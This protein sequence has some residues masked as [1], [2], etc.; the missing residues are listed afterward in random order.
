MSDNKYVKSLV[1]KETAFIHEV[2]GL[3]EDI[4]GYL[5]RFHL[6]AEN[7]LE[8][9]IA[10]QLRQPDRVSDAGLSFFQKA[11]W[12]HATDL[13]PDAA[14]RALRQMN[15]LRNKCSHQISKKVTLADI[16]A[17]GTP[18]GRQYADAKQQKQRDNAHLVLLL[19]NV[20]GW[21]YQDLLVAA[22]TEEHRKK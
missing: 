17:I 22:V 18:F 6:L 15:T 5:L 21:I 9:I 3:K 7:A 10:T 1:A 14:M 4:V 2:I 20:F 13:V 16:D 12:V 11:C 19:A 8:R